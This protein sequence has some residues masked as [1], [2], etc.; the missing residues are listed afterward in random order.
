[1]FKKQKPSSQKDKIRTEMQF[2]RAKANLETYIKRCQKLANEY[3]LKG[4]QAAKVSNTSMMRQFALGFKTMTEK[5]LGAEKILLSMESMNLSSDQNEL[6]GNFLEYAKMFQGTS[7]P[8]KIKP[9]DYEDMLTQIS[10]GSTQLNAIIDAVNDRI[11]QTDESDLDDIMNE[12]EEKESEVDKKL[13]AI[14]EMMKEEKKPKSRKK[15]EATE[16]QKLRELLE[17]LEKKKKKKNSTNDRD[18][19]LEDIKEKM[20]EIERHIENEGN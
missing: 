5:R 6:S 10:S 4:K 13:D 8:G 19:I 17:L 2:R 12:M 7:K 14:L 3:M 15:K 1:M 9:S 20:K 11:L 18:R 16:E